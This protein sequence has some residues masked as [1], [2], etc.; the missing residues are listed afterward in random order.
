[1]CTQDAVASTLV[2][3][4]TRLLDAPS[5]AEPLGLEVWLDGPRSW[6]PRCARVVVPAEGEDDEQLFGSE[7]GED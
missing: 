3:E 7:D 4:G 5:C 1:M 6:G 2:N